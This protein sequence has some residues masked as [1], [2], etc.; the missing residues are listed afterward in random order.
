[1]W[2]FFFLE[3]LGIGIFIWFRYKLNRLISVRVLKIMIYIF[4]WWIDWC[5]GWWY[6]WRL[7]IRVDFILCI[8]Y[9]VIWDER[10]KFFFIL[11]MLYEFIRIV[12]F[13]WNI[14]LEMKECNIYWNFVYVYL[15]ILFMFMNSCIIV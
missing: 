14:V 11:Y 3:K 4:I 9:I 10:E 15:L 7:Y 5:F 12:I 2:Y 6:D 13:G 1:M 8:L